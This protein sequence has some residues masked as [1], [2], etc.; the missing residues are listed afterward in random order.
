M[1]AKE[2]EKLLVEHLQESGEIRGD[3]KWLKKA[4][5]TL[6]GL[7]CAVVADRIARGH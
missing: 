6:I 3:I 4:F 2:V 7:F 1:K 5:W